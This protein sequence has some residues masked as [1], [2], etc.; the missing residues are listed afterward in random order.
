MFK[1]K[2][3]SLLYY[4]KNF[5]KRK[6]SNQGTTYPRI[7]EAA[8]GI[9]AYA[10]LGAICS[11]AKS[12]TYALADLAGAT[13]SAIGATAGATASVAVE[14]TA[15]FLKNA[16]V[17]AQ[18]LVSDYLRTYHLPP[19]SGSAHT[20]DTY[21]TIT[22]LNPVDII[23][24]LTLQN[25]QQIVM[26]ASKE[27]GV[28]VLKSYNKTHPKKDYSLGEATFGL[29]DPFDLQKRDAIVDQIFADVIKHYFTK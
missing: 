27:S 1:T 25:K 9:I 26:N 24:T 3:E 22:F 7:R 14:S 2:I 13:A 6:M 19:Y 11:V 4:F 18:G 28:F 16:S 15:D 20:P 17:S 5:K 21:Y 8:P 23:I 10:V 12:T 29:H